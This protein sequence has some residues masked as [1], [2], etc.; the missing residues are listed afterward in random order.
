[1]RNTTKI[2]LREDVYDFVQDPYHLYGNWSFQLKQNEGASYENYQQQAAVKNG[3]IGNGFGF[4][5]FGLYYV[6]DRVKEIN[7]S[8]GFLNDNANP[9]NF[10][11]AFGE[12]V[13]ITQPKFVTDGQGN[14]RIVGFE[15]DNLT[16]FQI[17]AF[18]SSI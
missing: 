8:G 17:G 16:G 2:W 12:D 3:T 7:A 11:I 14:K 6:D 18:A 13:K 9:Q 4:D 15:F 10:A 5:E 1:M